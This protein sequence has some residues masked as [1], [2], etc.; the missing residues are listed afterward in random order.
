MFVIY[1]YF[2]IQIL[3]FILTSDTID[4][5]YLILCRAEI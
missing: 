1:A 4:I 3:W 2:F 5:L